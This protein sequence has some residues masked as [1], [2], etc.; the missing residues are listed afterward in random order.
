MCSSDLSLSFSND[1]CLSI[2]QL[3]AQAIE[4]LPADNS[5]WSELTGAGGRA[6]LIIV[7]IGT[8]YQGTSIDADVVRR[9][10]KMGISL[11]LEIYTVP[12][13]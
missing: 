3:V 5:F 10:A 7:I 6:E 4:S 13:N 11:G 8:K 2:S 9:L 1:E 12:Q